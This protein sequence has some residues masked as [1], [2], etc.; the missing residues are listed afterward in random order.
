MT[1]A[2]ILAMMQ[3]LDNELDIGVGGADETRALAALNMAQDVFESILANQPDTLG[4]AGTT[5]STTASQEYTTWPST[6]LRLDSLWLLNTSV[7]PNVPQYQVDIIQ[8]VGGQAAGITFPGISGFAPQGFGSPL[9]A[10]TNRANFYWAPIPDQVYSL[11]PYGLYS[12]TDITSRSATFEYPDQVAAPMAAYADTLM[13]IGI[14]DPSET[15]AQLGDE[16]YG[17]VLKM[18]RRPVRQRPQSR[19]Y[20]QVHTT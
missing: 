19:Q 7:T 20:S 9:Q 1:I 3:V 2:A 4:V 16:M 15:I 13:T 10:Y 11:R 8:D 6:L 5:L 12:K 18:L 14:G 17:P